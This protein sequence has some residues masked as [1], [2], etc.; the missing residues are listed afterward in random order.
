MMWQRNPMKD[1]KGYLTDEQMDK[2]LE[3]AGQRSIRDLMLLVTLAYTGRR[4]SEIVRGT[5]GHGIKPQDID[6]NSGNITY[7]IMKKNRRTKQQIIE[8]QPHS[9]P[10]RKSLPCNPKLLLVLKK[11]IDDH[12]IQPDQ[13]IFDMTSQWAGLIIAAIGREAGI[14]LVGSRPLHPHHFRHTFAVNITRVS[15]ATPE[16]LKELQNLLQHSSIDMTMEYLRYGHTRARE[17]VGEL[18]YGKGL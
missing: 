10:I 14:G 6:Y 13:F 9:I 8:K 18:S 17:L 12:K 7:N 4:V 16:D 15:M 11:F 5:G 2:V 3:I 1:E